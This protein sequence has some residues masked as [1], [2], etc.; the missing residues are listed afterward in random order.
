MFELDE[1]ACTSAAAT[2]TR[3]TGR[4]KKPPGNEP[5]LRLAKFA[6]AA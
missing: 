1:E 5:R 2:A 3:E 6:D 4:R